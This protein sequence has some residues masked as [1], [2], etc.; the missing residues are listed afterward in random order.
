MAINNTV[1]IKNDVVRKLGISTTTSDFYTDT[2]LNGWVQQAGR[3]ATAFKKWPFAEGRVQTTYA[4]SEEVS[5]EGYKAD[6]FRIVTVGGK[7]LKKINFE[8]YLIMREERPNANDRVFSDFERIMF[9]NPNADVSGTLTAYGH[10]SPA[11]LDMTGG[12]TLFSD[13]DEEGNEAI[14]EEVLSYANVREKKLEEA[15]A[16]HQRAE[17]IL[18]GLWKRIEDEQFN[19]KTHNRGMWKRFDVLQGVETSDLIKR[20]QFI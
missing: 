20:D 5:F 12:T 16:H 13:F 11:N 7:L 19:Y 1:E 9:I 6:S 4:G 10:F 18:N 3:W 14:V 17:A 2:I 15:Q 8:D